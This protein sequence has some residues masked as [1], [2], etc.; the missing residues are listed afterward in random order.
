MCVMQDVLTKW[1]ELIPMRDERAETIAEAITNAI[2]LRHGSIEHLVTD[3]GTEFR[4]H[5]IGRSLFA[6]SNKPSYDNYRK[7]TGKSS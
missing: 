1:V 3:K 6:Q 5:T 4:N 7:S 2:T